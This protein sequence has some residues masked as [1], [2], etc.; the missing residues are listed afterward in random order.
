MKQL[1]FKDV[2]VGMEI[3]C[4]AIDIDLKHLITYSAVTWNFYLLHLDKEFA[5]KKGFKDV[6]VHAPFYGAILATLVNKW[7]GDPGGLK[8]QIYTV[9]KM[10]FRGDTLTSKGKVIRKYQK[11]GENLVDCDVWVENQHGV[12]LTLGSA[13]ISLPVKEEEL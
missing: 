1:F 4:L 9:R 11:S 8:K 10:G 5:Q 3:P 13:T 6:N 12:K 7:T 2:Y